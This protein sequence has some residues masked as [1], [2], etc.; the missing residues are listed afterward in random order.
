MKKHGLWA[1]YLADIELYQWVK[2]LMSIPM[3][4]TTMMEKAFQLIA[5]EKT[6]NRKLRQ[7]AS[8]LNEMLVYYKRQWLAPSMI[9]M[10]CVFDK[11]KRTNNYSECTC[12]GFHYLNIFFSL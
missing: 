7:F 5:K 8:Q 12:L 10:V 11:S 3:L 1:H 4:P 6:I 9:A 2:K